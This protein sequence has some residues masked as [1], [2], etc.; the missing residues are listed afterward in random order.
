MRLQVVAELRVL[1]VGMRVLSG[2]VC[3]AQGGGLG[4]NSASCTCEG[5]AQVR[6]LGWSSPR[7]R[8]QSL[9]TCSYRVMALIEG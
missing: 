6:V 8:A 9:V 3:W 2:R 5:V 7:M 4:T 1:V